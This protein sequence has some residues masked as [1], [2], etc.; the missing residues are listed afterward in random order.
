MRRYS[1]SEARRRIADVLDGAEHGEEVVIERKG[2]R[3]RVIVDRAG[4]V[5]VPAAGKKPIIEIRDP[6]VER[7][8]WTWRPTPGGRGLAFS[9]RR[10]SS[11]PLKRSR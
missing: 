8:E 6:A 9:A 7:G 2:V 1:T 10:S 3:F 4:P 11:S 5:R